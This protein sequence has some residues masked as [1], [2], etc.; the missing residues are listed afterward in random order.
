VIIDQHDHVRAIPNAKRGSITQEVSDRTLEVAAPYHGLTIEAFRA[1]LEQT[2]A[3]QHGQIS[4]ITDE[5]LVQDISDS[6]EATLRAEQGT[7]V[8]VEESRVDLEESW[9]YLGTHS[10][11]T[12]G[13]VGCAYM[14]LRGPL[15]DELIDWSDYTAPKD[16][17]KVQHLQETITS[18]EAEIASPRQEL[19][20]VNNADEER[21][22]IIYDAVVEGRHHQEKEAIHSEY[23]HKLENYQGVH[24]R[25]LE[26]LS[27]QQQI[28]NDHGRRDAHMQAAHQ[29][30]VDGFEYQRQVHI[31]I[32]EKLEVDHQMTSEA[33]VQELSQLKAWKQEM[34][35]SQEAGARELRISKQMVI[36]LQTENAQLKTVKT[37]LAVLGQGMSDMHQD[38]MLAHEETKKQIQACG[39][40]TSHETSD[41]TKQITQIVTDKSETLGTAVSH[42]H[43][44]TLRALESSTQSIASMIK[45]EAKAEGGLTRCHVSRALGKTID[46]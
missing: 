1:W 24:A 8:V 31:S 46:H 10:R 41:S 5:Y 27:E 33:K 30:Q 20:R 2:P 42:M 15:S 40:S 14:G 37:Q 11:L 45:Y 21:R 43:Q 7:D 34:L 22:E 16:Q 35:E 39:T 32:I 13:F 3:L 12:D 4:V 25:E 36:D 9:A 28:I 23:R 44:G 26:L 19:N 38:N 6:S 29:Q 17:Q 18:F